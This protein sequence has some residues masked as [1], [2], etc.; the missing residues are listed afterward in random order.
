MELEAKTGKPVISPLNVK[1]GI[2]TN[3]LLEDGE[4]KK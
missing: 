2:S 1:T 3:S 4:D